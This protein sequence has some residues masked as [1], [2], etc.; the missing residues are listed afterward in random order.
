M[1]IAQI[2]AEWIPAFAGMTPSLN[3]GVN[4]LEIGC[5]AW[6]EHGITTDAATS[7]ITT[8][9]APSG[10]SAWPEA[11]QSAA[12]GWPRATRRGIRDGCLPGFHFI[13]SG[14]LFLTGWAA[15]LGPLPRRLIPATRQTGHGL[16]RA[17]SIIGTRHHV[18]VRGAR[19]TLACEDASRMWRVARFQEKC[20][21]G[22]RSVTQ[23]TTNRVQYT[24]HSAEW[25]RPVPGQRPRRA[26]RFWWPR[27]SPWQHLP[28]CHQWQHLPSCHGWQHS[29]WPRAMH[30]CHS[31]LQH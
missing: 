31:A 13:L 24:L 18:R 19:P 29:G 22:E 16:W 30:L 26:R 1:N 21:L 3:V 6:M 5:V 15:G 23:Q 14:L 8:D 10:I 25:P 7:G 28:S 27:A 4:G 11:T 9:A 20:R 2:G 12:R 17:P